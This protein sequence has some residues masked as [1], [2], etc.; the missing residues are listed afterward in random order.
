[1][2]R[3]RYALQKMNLKTHVYETTKG[4][5]IWAYCN[6]P[7]MDILKIRELLGDDPLRISWDTKWAGIGRYGDYLFYIRRGK[8][9]KRKL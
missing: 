8:K 6:G 2:D 3:I 9:H 7:I 1:M 4:Y 5:H